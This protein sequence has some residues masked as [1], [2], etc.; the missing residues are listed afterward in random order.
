MKSLQKMKRVT[1][2]YKETLNNAA[3]AIYSAIKPYAP[4]KLK[5][6]NTVTPEEQATIDQLNKREKEALSKLHKIKEKVEELAAEK[7]IGLNRV[8]Y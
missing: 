8:E 5:D 7:N 1:N 3:D 2:K 4:L 6:F